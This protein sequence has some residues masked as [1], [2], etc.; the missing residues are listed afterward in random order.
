VVSSHQEKLGVLYGSLLFS[1]LKDMA[2]LTP[3]F[4]DLLW[5]ETGIGEES[6]V[7]LSQP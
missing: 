5:E 6:V 4:L 2:C 7:D 3:G 1:L